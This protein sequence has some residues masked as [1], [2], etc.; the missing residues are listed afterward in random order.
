MSRRPQPKTPEG[1]ARSNRDKALPKCRCGAIAKRGQ[2]R[3]SRCEDED[4]RARLEAFKQ[5]GADE[6]RARIVE[7]RDLLQESYDH[8]NYCGWGDSWERSA[9]TDNK[10]DDRMLAAIEKNKDIA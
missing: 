5:L 6:L 9:I 4:E 8:H 10:L 7:L 2:P 1:R 3:C